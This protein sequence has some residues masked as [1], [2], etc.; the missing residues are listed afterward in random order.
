MVN[1][2]ALRKTLPDR[3]RDKQ[4][5]SREGVQ[6]VTSAVL[7]ATDFDFETPTHVG[8]WISQRSKGKQKMPHN[9]AFCM[10]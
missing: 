4:D 3:R 5:E 2:T 9:R 10:I 8:E 1:A 6:R 7:G